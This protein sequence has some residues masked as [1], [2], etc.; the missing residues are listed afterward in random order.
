MNIE[1]GSVVTLKSGGQAMTVVS[2]ES[3]SADCLWCGEEG[4]FFRQT[5]PTIALQIAAPIHNGEEDDEEDEDD[6]DIEADDEA[7]SSKRT[8]A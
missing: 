5:I 1:A 3:E 2:V 6:E 8:A 4:D 7:I